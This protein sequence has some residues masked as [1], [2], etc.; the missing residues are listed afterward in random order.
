MPFTEK[1]ILDQLDAE[2]AA[3]TFPMLDNGYLYHAGQQLTLYRDAHRW[4]M[5]LE[6]IAWHN[7]MPGLDGFLNMAYTFG[8]C[9]GGDVLND[10]GNF[11]SFVENNGIPALIE[12]GDTAHLNPAAHS[13]RIKDRAVPL[14]H[15][16]AHYQSKGITLPA[17]EQIDR[18]ALLRGLLPEYAHLFWVSREEIGAKLPADLPEILTIAAW[19]HP[20]VAGKERPGESETFRQLAKVLVTGDVGHYRPSGPPNTYWLNW[21]EGGRL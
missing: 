9:I 1:E 19:H 4:A 15:D 5:L 13:I 2:A 10:A 20:D 7:R 16:A 14:R 17:G 8:N 12:D 3:F 6:V 11:F 18:A 21:P